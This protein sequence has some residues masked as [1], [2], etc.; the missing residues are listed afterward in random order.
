MAS[1]LVECVPNFSEGRDPAV[2]EALASAI[3]SAPGANVLD[4]EMDADHHR[5]VITFT[6]PP[7]TVV[8]AALA[9]A[10]VAVG[11][12]DLN[13]Q[14]GVHPRIGALDVLPFVPLEGVTIEECASLAMEAGHRLWEELRVPV[15]YYEA[16]ARRESRRMLENVRRGQFE[17]LREAALS[18]PD[19]RPDV[20][21]PGLHPTA[22]ATAVGARKILIA[23]NINL[24]TTDIEIARAIARVIRA[25]NGG[26]PC[27]KA[28]GVPL[29]SRGLTQVSMNLTDFETTP[30]HTV[31]EAVS[32]EAQRRGVAIHS[33]EI[34][35][36][37]PRRA[38]EMAAEHFLRFGNFAPRTVLERRIEDA[39]AQR[40]SSKL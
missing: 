5:S 23:W 40:L 35:G 39:R 17:I 3:L 11:R 8:E 1:P 25:S 18:D 4:V 20:G 13:Q 19:R 2:V 15:Y 7:S 36:L 9:A 6:A 26:L 21:G 29:A 22:G 38:L 33:S 12:I 30:M 37:L 10:R 31:F 14:R 32:R 28:L 24:D 34:I 16:A 27:V